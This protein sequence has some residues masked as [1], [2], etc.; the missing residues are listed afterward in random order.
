MIITVKQDDHERDVG[1][2]TFSI[3]TFDEGDILGTFRVGGHPGVIRLWLTASSAEDYGGDPRDLDPFDYVVPDLLPADN[4][5]MY[6]RGFVWS[7][8]HI[9][10]PLP[11]P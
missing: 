9:N 1:A 2:R 11:Y 3:V 6:V 5:Y 10:L 8:G 7:P 4:A